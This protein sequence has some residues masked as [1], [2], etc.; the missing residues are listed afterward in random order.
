[1]SDF[2]HEVVDLS[3]VLLPST[4]SSPSPSIIPSPSPSVY[5]L[6]VS[7]G[8]QVTCA[9]AAG[10]GG[11][12]C[13]GSGTYGQLGVGNWSNL[14]TPGP[15]VVTGASALAVGSAHTCTVEFGTGGLRCWGS[16]PGNGLSSALPSPPSSYLATG[17]AQVAAG[18]DFTCVLMAVNGGVRC[19]GVNTSGQLGMG[20]SS[21]STPPLFPSSDAFVGA[22]QLCT[23]DDF[24]CV[25][26]SN[27]SVLCWGGNL[28]G[29]LGVGSMS[30]LH[31][32]PATTSPS[33]S[34]VSAVACGSAHT[35]AL[36]N[37][38]G[39]RCWGSNQVRVSHFVAG[40]VCVALFVVCPRE[41]HA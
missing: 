21:T 27:S 19:F 22:T 6:G 18:K 23:G 5:G 38:S 24:T 7:A 14:Y 35:C 29:Q 31:L 16:S 28:Y 39:V 30:G 40:C 32:S 20:Y 2:T 17:V 13:F 25:V 36:T 26:A 11:V 10:S 15:Y 33:L 34:S 3:D 8:N 9:I 41:P 1:M 12:S 37:T 4:S